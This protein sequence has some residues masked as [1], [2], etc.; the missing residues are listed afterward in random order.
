M[1]N[2]NQIIQKHSK[3]LLLNLIIELVI[4]NDGTKQETFKLASNLANQIINYE[5]KGPLWEKEE[6]YL[7]FNDCDYDDDFNNN[8]HKNNINLNYNYKNYFNKD[9]DPILIKYIKQILKIF[10]ISKNKLK[11]NWA[12]ESIEWMKIIN[13]EKNNNKDKDDDNDDDD[14]DDDENE[15]ID[16][17]LSSKSFINAFKL[18]N[19]I[20]CSI[21]AQIRNEDI[22]QI[23]LILEYIVNSKNRNSEYLL[24]IL[25]KTLKI[26][27][28]RIDSLIIFPQLFWVC[29]SLLEISNQKTFF[30]IIN[31]I[32]KLLNKGIHKIEI[33][34]TVLQ[35]QPFELINNFKGIHNLITKGF[36]FSNNFDP[37]IFD[38]LSICTM[39]D[40]PELIGAREK[41][42]NLTILLISPY[43]AQSIIDPKMKRV[44]FEYLS[45]LYKVTKLMGKK[46][47]YN[48]FRKFSK[49]FFKTKED[50]LKTI[51]QT[52]YKNLQLNEKIEIFNFFLQIIINGSLIYNND[53]L[54]IFE[55][56]FLHTN[57]IFQND[58]FV[59]TKDL[60]FNFLNLLNQENSNKIILFLQ[61][62][63]KK[64]D[65]NP[66]EFQISLDKFK[67]K[68]SIVKN[69]NKNDQKKLKKTERDH[70]IKQKGKKMK[71][72]K[73]MVA[74]NNNLYLINNYKTFPKIL[75]NQLN[76]PKRKFQIN[77][78]DNNFK[79]ETKSSNNKLTKKIEEEIDL[80][81]NSQP[82]ND[83]VFFFSE[84]IYDY[85]ELSDE[86]D[87][88]LIVNEV[89]K[90]I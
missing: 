41:Q 19:E 76:Q 67:N 27:I 8:E 47:I 61:Y 5:N 10:N 68:T 21:Q 20:Y 89:L 42:I 16:K 22:E 70:K 72:N 78:I 79:T 18:S 40:S 36:L 84:D 9:H 80:K 7:N 6:I 15:Y 26:I 1:H 14:D 81:N 13:N 51:S 58:S 44:A 50:F 32:K 60:L 83:N 11:K 88:D 77:E 64:I 43:L 33:Q 30:L 37:I 35:A 2:P 86:P 24:L 23:I 3:Q 52:I 45:R 62:F 48:V 59:I 53:F 29:S 57:F 34:Q 55:Y 38:L 39:I 85:G 66:K 90:Q 49:K 54:I 25:I 63:F 73:K 69:E 4:N 71:K 12:L 65:K 75:E 46:N 74:K 87:I 31:L 82:K 17:L 56:L 28:N